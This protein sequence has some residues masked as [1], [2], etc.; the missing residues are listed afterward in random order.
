VERLRRHRG[1][2]L[3]S[4]CWS[5]GGATRISRDDPKG[6]YRYATS[7]L[8][9]VEWD[10]YAAERSARQ[11]AVGPLLRRLQGRALQPPQRARRAVHAL[12]G[13]RPR[14]G[15]NLR[16]DKVSIG[17]SLSGG[18]ELLHPS[19]RHNL[20]ALAVRRDPARRP[21]RSQPVVL[22]HEARAPCARRDPDRSGGLE[23]LSRLSYAEPLSMSGSLNLTIHWD[24]TNGARNDRFSDI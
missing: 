14:R 22:D 23:Q 10:K 15:G 13:A 17:L 11:P 5:F 18:G 1:R 8:V 4:D 24:R 9:G 12:P 20:S 3:H 16:K 6:Q 2:W 7:A 21:R 19:R